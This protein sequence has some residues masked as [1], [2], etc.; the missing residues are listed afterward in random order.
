MDH[1]GTRKIE[2]ERLVLRAFTMEDAGPAYRNWTSDDRVT[3]FLTWPVHMDISET[4]DI[5]RTWISSYSRPD[6]YQWAIVPKELGEPVGTISVVDMDESLSILH[7]GYCIGRRWWHMGITSEAL[8]A[9]IDFLFSQVDV[10]RIESQHDPDNPHSGD[11]MR[12]CGMRYEGTLRQAD[13]SNR[14]IVDAS[15]YSILRS[16]W[17]QKM[18][19][20]K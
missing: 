19:D 6:F 17:E 11:V 7:I 20:R 3:E 8:D 9:V 4:E 10:N 15:I 12:K 5:L 1:V 16:E 2:T 14:G 13:K 18:E